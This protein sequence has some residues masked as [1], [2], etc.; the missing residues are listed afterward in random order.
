RQKTYDA[1]TAA[2]AAFPQ[3]FRTPKLLDG[4]H[5]ALLCYPVVV[6][7]DAPFKRADLQEAIEAAGIDTRTIWTGN[8]ARHPF[9]DG[10][11]W[12]QPEGGMPEADNVFAN[13][14][15]LGMSHGLSDQD[16]QRVC[17]AITDFASKW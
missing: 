2:Y 1:Y 11:E 13:G 10:V 14:M 12:R 8:A 5:T 7:E 17:D 3:F 15:S 9:L 16:V 6:R 4:L